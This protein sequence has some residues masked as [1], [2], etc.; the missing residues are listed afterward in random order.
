MYTV[1]R[2][3][4]SRITILD[5]IKNEPKAEFPADA[6]IMVVRSDDAGPQAI[7]ASA[8]TNEEIVAE[9]DP[10]REPITYACPTTS[11]TLLARSAERCQEDANSLEQ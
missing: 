2:G 4:D 9:L 8:A 5:A 3:T 11:Q 7:R 6:I 10:R 1:V